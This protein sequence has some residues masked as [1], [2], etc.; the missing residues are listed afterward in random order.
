MSQV[1]NFV[2]MMTIKENVEND[3]FVIAELDN[4]SYVI[5]HTA[6]L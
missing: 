5:V 2:D 6:K 4:D 1:F 3:A